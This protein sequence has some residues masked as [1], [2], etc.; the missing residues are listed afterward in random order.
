MAVLG[1]RLVTGLV[2]RGHSVSATTT[3]TAKLALLQR[4]GAVGHLLDGLDALSV[5]E[6]VAG[7]RPDVIVN[8]MTGISATSA[9]GPRRRSDQTMA[10]TRRLRTEGIDHLL[11]AAQ[12]T[13]VERVVT[14]SHVAFNGP[15]AGGPFPPEDDLFSVTERTRTTAYLERQVVGAGGAALRYGALYG[16]ECSEPHVAT[17]RRRVPPLVRRTRGLTSWVHVEDAA[18]ATVL[19]VETNCTGVFNVVDDD[20]APTSEWLPH[21]AR[22]AGARPPLRVPG[23]LKIR[24]YQ[25]VGALAD[26]YPV[27]NARTKREL[28]WALRFPSWRQGFEEEL[29]TSRTEDRQ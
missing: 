8:Q 7:A 21:L 20:P 27:S 26:G 10:A 19:A 23:A 11:A 12:A 18:F 3:D 29:M 1:R 28:G 15:H 2:A 9:P 14:H 6:V 4:L 13:G 24:R 22:C 16:A 25:E 5:G 17:V